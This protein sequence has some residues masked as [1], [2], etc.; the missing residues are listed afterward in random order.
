[1]AVPKT[2][3]EIAK[4]SN[5]RLKTLSRDYRIL[6]TELDLKVPN[7]DLRQYVFKV[8]NLFPQVRKLKEKQ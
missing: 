4:A 3:K 5:I 7:N 6:I 2:L 8:G 1:M